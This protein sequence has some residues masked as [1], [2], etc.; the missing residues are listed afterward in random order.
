VVSD[1]PRPYKDFL[2][3]RIIN[4][5]VF[6][7]CCIWGLLLAIS[8]TVLSV[9]VYERYLTPAIILYF[10]C[11]FALCC[12]V[13]YC[14]LQRR[15]RFKWRE[16]IKQPATIYWGENSYSQYIWQRYT[17]DEYGKNGRDSVNLYSKITF[18]M[19]SILVFTYI[20]G[21][22]VCAGIYIGGSNEAVSDFFPTT[23]VSFFIPLPLGILISY[24]LLNYLMLSRTKRAKAG[25]AEFMLNEKGFIW[26]DNYH[27]FDDQTS[28]FKKTFN[29]L[30]DMRVNQYN[31]Q[32]HPCLEICVSGEPFTVYR[33]P[34]PDGKLEEVQQYL[35]TYG[36]GLSDNICWITAT[37]PQNN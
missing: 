13:P 18:Y 3:L 23:L 28:C 37:P 25:P 22:F 35:C 8:F 4:S 17:E 21:A 12:A 19:L 2:L 20:P 30:E 10:C 11:A 9:Y 36:Y 24:L 32:Q 16:L 26:L 5:Y 7:S 34:I 27:I 29:H 33:I 15:Y 31:F 1:T 6:I 14:L